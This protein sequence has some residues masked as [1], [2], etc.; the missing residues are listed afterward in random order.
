ML[1]VKKDRLTNLTAR[2]ESQEPW[3]CN[4]WA[5]ILLTYAVIIYAAPLSLTNMATDQEEITT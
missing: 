4:T 1:E 2:N 5:S 3:L